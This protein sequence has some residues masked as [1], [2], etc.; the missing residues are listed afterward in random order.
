MLSQN[1]QPFEM[2]EVVIKMQR[3]EKKKVLEHT[4]HQLWK[5]QLQAR[6]GRQENGNKHS[7]VQ[8]ISEV[9][10]RGPYCTLPGVQ[11]DQCPAAAWFTYTG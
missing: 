9:G 2:E 3:L 10:E 8:V 1:I 7:A 4:K 6:R 11:Q 5:W